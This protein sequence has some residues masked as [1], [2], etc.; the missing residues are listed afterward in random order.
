MES[1]RR[2]IKAIVTAAESDARCNY[3]PVKLRKGREPGFTKGI[4]ILEVINSFPIF[5][6]LNE[7]VEAMFFFFSEKRVEI[8]VRNP[9]LKMVSVSNGEVSKEIRCFIA[10]YT[11]VIRYPY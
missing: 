1:S 3:A 2:S 4:I 11:L 10:I 9:D 6:F 7:R 8:S 5:P